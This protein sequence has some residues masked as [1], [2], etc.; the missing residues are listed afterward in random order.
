MHNLGVFGSLPVKKCF[1]DFPVTEINV[2]VRFL[3]LGDI[4]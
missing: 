2:H 4:R 3:S 1:P